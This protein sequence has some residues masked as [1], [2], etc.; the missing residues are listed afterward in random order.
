MSLLAELVSGILSDSVIAGAARSRN[1]KFLIGFVLLTSLASIGLLC[2]LYSLPTVSAD[3]FYETE[4]S[5]SGA[6]YFKDS[7]NREIRLVSENKEYRIYSRIWE[8]D[9]EPETIVRQLNSTNKATIWIESSESTEVKGIR[10]TVFSIDPDVGAGWDN[11]NNR[12]GR[13]MGW[14]FLFAGVFLIVL[15]WA[16]Y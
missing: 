14:I 10:A 8:K 16:F 6:Y 1:K 11:Q 9:F 13:L 4:I 5:F 7:R 3:S 15:A 2:Y 12:T